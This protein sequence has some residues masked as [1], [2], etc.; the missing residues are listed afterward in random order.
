MAPINETI[1]YQERDDFHPQSVFSD[2][3]VSVQTGMLRVGNDTHSLAG[4][5]STKLLLD[6][7]Q[8]NR[9]QKEIK[10]W[11]FGVYLCYVIAII[12]GSFNHYLYSLLFVATAMYVL[13]DN[14]LHKA[15]ILD[16][17]QRR[18]VATLVLT[19]NGSDSS[20]VIGCWTEC[21][22]FELESKMEQVGYSKNDATRINESHAKEKYRA[23]AIAKA[24]GS[25]IVDI[26]P[27]DRA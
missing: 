13:Y 26:S 17:I 3:P 23:E 15:K 11:R 5:S 24:V 21:L 12:A 20:I 25:A 19:R 6:V 8:P 16:D 1:Y 2:G 27:V 10:P 7:E 9:N 4:V 14:R 22:T 18:L